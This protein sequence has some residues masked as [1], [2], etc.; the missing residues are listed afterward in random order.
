MHPVKHNSMSRF[1]A[2]PFDESIIPK[3]SYPR[4]FVKPNAADSSRETA[5]PALSSSSEIQ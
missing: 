5:V 4:E 2:K 1:Q 3:V